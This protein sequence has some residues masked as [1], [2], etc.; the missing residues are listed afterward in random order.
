LSPVKQEIRWGNLKMYTGPLQLFAFCYEVWSL[1]LSYPV[2]CEASLAQFLLWAVPQRQLYLTLAVSTSQAFDHIGS[3]NRRCLITFYLWRGYSIWMW[4]FWWAQYSVTSTRLALSKLAVFLCFVLGCSQEFVF[5]GFIL[6]QVSFARR[7][8]AHPSG[9]RRLG[10]LT[11]LQ[12]IAQDLS[13][14][15][16]VTPWLWWAY[17]VNFPQLDICSLTCA[18]L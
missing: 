9:C 6:H 18:D 15:V 17:V 1:V 3:V 11:I 5:K 12:A 16:I 13:S 8:V 14:P 7:S 2:P 4:W 10:F